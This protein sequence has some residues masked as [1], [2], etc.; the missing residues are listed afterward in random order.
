MRDV[1]A[2]KFE[3]G[4]PEWLDAVTELL[5]QAVSGV[6]LGGRSY[7]VSEEFTDA[8]AHLVAA[9]DTSIAWHFRVTDGKVDV[10]R[11]VLDDADL[12]TTVD[13]QA[14]LPVARL[15]Y[16][17]TPDAMAEADRLRTEARTTG[18]RVGDETALPAPLLER[19]VWL[20]NELA[21]RTL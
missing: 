21:R 11:G 18:E 8:P 17:S 14:V 6:D 15:V 7:A 4:S 20:H 3:F 16:E 2:S 1:G 10:G 5:D 12:K 9:G 19:L 13:Y